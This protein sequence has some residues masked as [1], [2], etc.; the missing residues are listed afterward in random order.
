MNITIDNI[1]M[2]K[3][4]KKPKWQR[5]E[6]LAKNTWY[7]WYDWF[8]NYFSDPI[9]AKRGAKDNMILFKTKD[10]IEPKCAES[11]H[12]VGKKPRKLKSKK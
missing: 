10:D 1:T 4:E 2:D 6:R 11:D 12:G 9:K 3:F 7:K 8:I 5:R